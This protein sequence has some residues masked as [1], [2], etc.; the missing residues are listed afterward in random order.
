MEEAPN[1]R[2][3][4]DCCINCEYGCIVN[5]DLSVG[6][7]CPMVFCDKYGLV[8]PGGVCDDWEED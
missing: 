4:G 1:F 6:I 8:P 3:G 5:Y 7:G 2:H